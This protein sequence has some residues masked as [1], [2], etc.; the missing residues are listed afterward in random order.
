MSVDLKRLETALAKAA[1]ICRENP[2]YLPIFIRIEKEISRFKKRDD[3]FKR[4]ETLASND[5][6]EAFVSPYKAVA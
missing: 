5:K 2:N 3:T 4:I 6:V 1:M